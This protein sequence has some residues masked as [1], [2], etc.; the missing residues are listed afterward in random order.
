MKNLFKTISI[1]F[2]VVLTMMSCSKED[3]AKLNEDGKHSSELPSETLLSMGQEQFFY[4]ATTPNVNYNNFRFFTQQIVETTYFD[5]SRYDF[6]RNQ[7]RNNWD[8]MYV[9]SLNNF[10]QAK[11]NLAEEILADE[12]TRGNKQ[13]T[14]EIAEIIV[15]EHL[16]DTYG[17]VPYFDALNAADDNFAPVYDDARA[18]YDDLVSRVDAV[19]GTI[20][21][22]KPGYGKG[23]L[24]YGGDMDK[25]RK[26]ANSIKFR[27]AM[28]LADVDPSTSV[29]WANEALNAG[30][31]DSGEAAF[32]MDFA[33]GT[34]NNPAYDDIDVAGS[35][36]RD[37]VISEI[38]IDPMNARNDPRRA[39]WFTTVDG[40]FIGG[41]P[42]IGNPFSSNSQY[43][44]TEEGG[45]MLEPTAS[46]TLISYEEIL[47][48]QAEA[49]A[50]GGGY[51]V[52]NPADRYAEAVLASME[53]NGVDG[54][55]AQAYLNSNPYNASNWKESI[56]MEAYISLFEKTFAS[57]TFIRRLDYPV[58]ENPESSLVDGVPVRMLYSDQEYL[59]N[60]I[61]TEAAAEAIGGDEVTTKLFWD[62]N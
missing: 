24:V 4:Y 58:L 42:G 60:G 20:D 61:N 38:V 25:W 3:L 31:I 48:L 18:I 17:N 35:G 59:L 43:L 47:L 57:W 30:V 9:N 14:L 29:Q 54:A 56:G 45:F 2:L 13:A 40:D 26:A 23:D 41:V 55:D 34:F 21:T 62:V 12:D 39:V 46:A 36:R 50:R 16:V 6:G 52:S 5:E 44:P 7:P 53:L 8:R 1:S 22:S 15:W 11:K 28:N 51:N 19:V 32:A 37:F 10:A 27:M 33:G 49:A